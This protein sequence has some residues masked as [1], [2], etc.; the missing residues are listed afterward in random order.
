MGGCTL[1]SFYREQERA[2]IVIVIILAKKKEQEESRI[3]YLTPRHTPNVY[4]S[5]VSFVSSAKLTKLCL[6]LRWCYKVIFCPHCARSIPLDMGTMVCIYCAADLKFVVHF[7]FAQNA[8]AVDYNEHELDSDLEATDEE[9]LR[10]RV[11]EVQPTQEEEDDVDLIFEMRIMKC[12]Q[13]PCRT[14]LRSS[15]GRLTKPYEPA[16]NKPEDPVTRKGLNLYFKP[17]CTTTVKDLA[18]S[19]P[20]VVGIFPSSPPKESSPTFSGLRRNSGTVPR[21]RT[22]ADYGGRPGGPRSTQRKAPAD[23]EEQ[24]YEESLSKWNLRRPL[25]LRDL[26]QVL[27]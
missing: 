9:P 25:K 2:V 17:T 4:A 11:E 1:F 27:S 26:N 18:G 16:P 5:P 21:W 6:T 7:I 22:K 20:L 13:S 15:R 24:E 19:I 10:A 12:Q 23:Q 3:F 14:S 8:I